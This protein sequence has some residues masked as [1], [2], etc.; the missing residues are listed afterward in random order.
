MKLI[1]ILAVA[2]FVSS[3][4]LCAQD[5]SVRVQLVVPD[6][7][8]VQIVTLKDGTVLNGRII[9]IS[10]ETVVF[11]AA[12]GDIT[13][14][15]SQIKNVKSIPVSMVRRG[16]YWFPNPNAT[17]LFIAPTGRMLKQGDG[18]FQN[19]YIFFVGGAFGVTDNITIG[20]GS[21]IVPGT[22]QVYYVTP[23]VG[24]EVARNINIAAGTLFAGSTE[25]S[26]H[27]G[28]H[29]AV[30][31]FGTREGSL[32]LGV[33]YGYAGSDVSSKPIFVIGGEK[34]FSKRL[35]VV[36]E[37]WL[38]PHSDAPLASFGIRFLGESLAA[39][40]GLWRPLSGDTSGWG[41]GF[42]YVDFVVNIK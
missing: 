19:I 23:K 16:E 9:S 1:H 15:I 4:S 39:D 10:S 14:K 34:R 36:T 33:G 42:P 35:A 40:L 31:S 8:T 6:S 20:G 3:V 21:S 37:N 41:L 12:V 27:V 29:Y 18:Y 25:E 26:E 13:V 32:T 11:Q 22:S 28:I 2:V 30:G 7:D 24:F 5:E 38:I 17:R